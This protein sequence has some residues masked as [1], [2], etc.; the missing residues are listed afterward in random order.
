LIIKKNCVNF[1]VA[2]GECYPYEA[3]VGRCRAKKGDTLRSMQCELA[4][5]QR[6]QLY[7]MG[8]AYSL[9]NE[10][11]IMWEI[12]NYGPVQGMFERKT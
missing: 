2:D 11:D 10:T 12:F 3:A 9:N 6:D 1:S 4:D 7:K 5:N 8:P